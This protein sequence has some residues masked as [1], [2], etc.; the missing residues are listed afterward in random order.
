MRRLYDNASGSPAPQKDAPKVLVLRSLSGMG[1]TTAAAQ[2]ASDMTKS[3]RLLACYFAGTSDRSS[4]LGLLRSIAVQVREM[5]PESAESKGLIA[6][7]EEVDGAV[8]AAGITDALK[9]VDEPPQTMV[10]AS[11]FVA[12][13]LSPR[14]Q[15]RSLLQCASQTDVWLF[16]K[17]IDYV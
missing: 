6:A 16:Q 10:G 17:G 14:R 5:L 12:L 2:L 4:A 7:K 9:S 15:D 11:L 3:G 1:K 8:I 13:H